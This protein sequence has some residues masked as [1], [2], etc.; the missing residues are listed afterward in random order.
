MYHKSRA[1][2]RFQRRRAINRKLHIACNKGFYASEGLED[3]RRK[4]Q[5]A[6]GKIHCSCPLCSAKST[7]DRGVRNKSIHNY[8]ITD[9]RVLLDFQNQLAS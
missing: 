3:P 8:K 1:Y 7:R 4:G 5:L 9:Q 6:K 2:R